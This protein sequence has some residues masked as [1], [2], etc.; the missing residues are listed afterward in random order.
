MHIS[1]NWLKDF[2]DLPKN[3]DP[4]DLAEQLTLKT[5]EVEAVHQAGEGLEGMV[6]GEIKEIKKHPD[7]DKL[8]IAKVN[9]GAK[10]DL[11]IVCGGSNLKEGMYVAVTI[12]GA[13]VR[14]HGEGEPVEVKHTKIRGVESE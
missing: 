10:K 11:Q 1:L 7:A 13:F 6:V 4:K 14:W 5:A 12:K 9:V 3:L 8:K 2:V